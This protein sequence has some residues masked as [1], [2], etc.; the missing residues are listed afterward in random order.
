MKNAMLNEGKNWVNTF[1]TQLKTSEF[2]SSV[3]NEIIIFFI[4]F[5]L[6]TAQTKSVKTN[7]YKF[8]VAKA[9]KSR[10]GIWKN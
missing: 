10:W 3:V 6:F 7:L 2:F 4:Y 1:Q 8:S 5:I 9:L